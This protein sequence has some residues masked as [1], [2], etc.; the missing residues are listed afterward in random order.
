MNR[1]T[2]YDQIVE[3]V[4]DTT[5]NR[6]QST[7]SYCILALAVRCHKNVQSNIWEFEI[8]FLP[9][10]AFAEFVA[11]GCAENRRRH[12]VKGMERIEQRNEMNELVE[13]FHEF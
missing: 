13:T 4:C 7:K 1:V 3:I 11:F 10:E 5:R 8:G 12:S 6:Q 2:T 9:I